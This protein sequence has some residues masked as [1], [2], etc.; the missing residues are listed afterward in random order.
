MG[1]TRSRCFDS[2]RFST[3]ATAAAQKAR[4]SWTAIWE[5]HSDWTWKYIS[6]WQRSSLQGNRCVAGL[7]SGILLFLCFRPWSRWAANGPDQRQPSHV[8]ERMEAQRPLHTFHPRRSTGK[9]QNNFL[10]QTWGWPHRVAAIK[11]R[12]AALQRCKPLF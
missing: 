6:D 2:W 9:F 10:L 3:E 1:R 5:S 8:M 7:W 4:H 12:S 11:K